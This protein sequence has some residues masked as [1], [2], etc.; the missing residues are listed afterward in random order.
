MYVIKHI[1][2]DA[3][4]NPN[5]ADIWMDVDGTVYDKKLLLGILNIALKDLS[6]T[7]SS[8]YSALGH[9]NVDYVSSSNVRT[10]AT[11]GDSIFISPK[12]VTYFIDKYGPKEAAQIVEYVLIHECFHILYNHC[13]EHMT[14]MSKFPDAD[15]VNMAQDFQINYDIEN[16][17]LGSKGTPVFKGLTKKAGGLYDEKYGGKMWQK[18]YPEIFEDG[19]LVPRLPKQ[20]TPP[21]WKQGFSDG[22]AEVIEE[23]RKQKLIEQCQIL[24]KM[25]IK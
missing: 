2:E 6:S 13:Y 5:D 18:I 22:Y 4:N 19:V 8:I 14:E 10:M 3:S 25:F 7:Y 1:N 23:L 17:I 9:V 15:V 12:F 20:Q 11:D 16:F 24:N 21:E